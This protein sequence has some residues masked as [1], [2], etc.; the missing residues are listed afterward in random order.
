MGFFK[1]DDNGEKIIRKVQLDCSNDEP[2]T[3]QHHLAEVNINA[4][5]KRHGMD[6]I[7][8]TALLRSQEFQFDDVTGN[9]F[10][11]AML[12]ITK[13]QETFESLPSALRKKFDNNPAQ[14]LDFVQNPENI[15]ELYSMGLAQRPPKEEPVQVVVTNPP[16]DPETPPS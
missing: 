6:I 3:E 1:Y 2:I 7:Q 16:T 4:I 5:I 10:Q 8:K 11:E 9:D 12:K 15:E 14:Y 13:A